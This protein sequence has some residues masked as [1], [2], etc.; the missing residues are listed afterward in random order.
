MLEELKNNQNEN[1]TIRFSNSALYIVTADVQRLFPN[2]ETTLLLLIK[3][4]GIALQQHT[5]NGKEVRKIFCGSL[6]RCQIVITRWAPDTDFDGSLLK[7]CYYPI[8]EQ[9]LQP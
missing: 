5:D 8:P 7:K 9:V 3:A 2:I 6:K 1:I 4:L